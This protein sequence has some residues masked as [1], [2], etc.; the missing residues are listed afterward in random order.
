MK[1]STA[2]AMGALRVLFCLTALAACSD[3]DN[4]TT[5]QPSPDGGLSDSGSPSTAS[6][7]YLVV[8]RVFAP[9]GRLYYASVLPSLPKGKIDR[10]KAREFS[11]AD[12]ETFDGK[13]FLRDRQSNTMTRFAVSDDLKLVQEAQFSFANLGLPGSRVTNA[14]VSPTS[15]FTLNAK[16]WT[17][18]EWNPTA[19]SLTGKNVSIAAAKKSV[20]GFINEPIRFGE[21]IMA[22]VGWADGDTYEM[23]PGAGVIVLDPKTP[24][25]PRFIETPRIGNGSRLTLAANGDA[26][27]YSVV[28]AEWRLWGKASNG[29]KLPNSGVVRIKAGQTTY[30]PDYHVDIEAIT[31]SP[32]VWGIHR[33]D[34]RYLLVQMWDPAVS[35]DFVKSQEDL[36]NAFEY[37]Y[38]LVDTQEKT[39]KKVD[40]IPKGGAGSSDDHIVDGKLHVQIYVPNGD[41]PDGADAVVYSVTSAGFTEEFRIPSGDLWFVEKLR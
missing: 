9:E 26:Y 30:D 35:I 33:V 8:E 39:W 19:M 13:I 15:A 3:D 18:A 7:A 40:T 16:D 20:V 12:V 36:D 11:S 14:Y 17:L 34:D 41:G 24:D 31:K 6:S 29:G 22:P 25:A 5:A 38:A 2:R 10:S 1:A 23:Y 27:Q 37:I 28:F 32:N 4:S 21:T